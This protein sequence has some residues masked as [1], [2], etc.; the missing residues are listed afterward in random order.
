MRTGLFPTF[1]SR[2]LLA[3]LVAL[4]VLLALGVASKVGA[5]PF[6]FRSVAGMSSGN[7]LSGMDS[8][9]RNSST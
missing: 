5:A 9:V 3:L 2:A 1:H 4:P 8:R 6:R 7:A